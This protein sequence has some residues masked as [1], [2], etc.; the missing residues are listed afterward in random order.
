VHLMV[1]VVSII[2]DRSGRTIRI[3]KSKVFCENGL[4]HSR[5]FCVRWGFFGHGY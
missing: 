3:I 2:H 4:N 1:V 5:F